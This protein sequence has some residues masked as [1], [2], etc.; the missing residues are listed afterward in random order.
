MTSWYGSQREDNCERHIERT[1]KKE[2]L[3]HYFIRLQKVTKITKAFIQDSGPVAET[4]DWY[5]LIRGKGVNVNFCLTLC[6]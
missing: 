3:K 6:H 2:I 5:L 1:L 4:G